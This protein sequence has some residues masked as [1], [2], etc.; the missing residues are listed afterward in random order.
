MYAQVWFIYL[1]SCVSVCDH[2]DA[3]VVMG[4][5]LFAYLNMSFLVGGW[6]SLV[7]CKEIKYTRKK[8]RD[9]YT[10]SFWK[11]YSYYLVCLTYRCRKY[12][13]SVQAI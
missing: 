3:C 9:K 11:Q 12:H 10:Y 6:C 2:M 1:S 8:S 4:V 13:E 7:T 5:K